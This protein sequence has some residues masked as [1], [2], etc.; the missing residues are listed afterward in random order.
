MTFRLVQ[1]LAA[2]AVPIAVACRVLRVSESGFHAWRSR[3]PSRRDVSDVALTATLREI[4]AAAR[5]TYGVRRMHAEL[6]LGRHLAI[7]YR[8]VFRLMRLAG[9]QGVHHR[10]WRRGA[11]GR[12]PAVF[13]DRVQRRFTAERPDQLW[14]ADITQH[15]TA[16]IPAIVATPTEEVSQWR[17]RD[18]PTSRRKSSSG[19]LIE[20]GPFELLREQP[21]FTRTPDTTGCARRG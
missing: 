10:K 16:W 8:R 17:R 18:T 11:G 12:L 9:L 14:V 3:P 21:G 6:R 5:G 19:F 4:H 13:E 15:R 20:E 7:G 2:D 1:E